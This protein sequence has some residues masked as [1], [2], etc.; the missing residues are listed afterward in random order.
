MRA[1]DFCDSAPRAR[2][3]VFIASLIT[4][5]SNKYRPGLRLSATGTHTH[6]RALR[7]RRVCV[8]MNRRGLSDDIRAYRLNA[9]GAGFAMAL[10][11]D[12]QSNGRDD[13]DNHHTHACTRESTKCAFE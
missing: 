4:V 5:A 13:D 10:N 8:M 7:R 9:V 11:P 12:H 1:G 3:F 2:I 6:T